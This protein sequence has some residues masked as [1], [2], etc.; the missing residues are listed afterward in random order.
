[1]AEAQ[2]TLPGG[3]P[4]ALNTTWADIQLAETTS[5]SGLERGLNNYKQESEEA[6]NAQ[7][8]NE[9]GVYRSI[10]NRMNAAGGLTT[11]ANTRGKASQYR[12]FAERRTQRSSAL[13]RRQGQYEQS[14]LEREQAGKKSRDEVLG[15]GEA[16]QREQ[17][18][19]KAANEP[20]APAPPAASAQPTA[21]APPS[22]GLGQ[23]PPG[24]E[25]VKLP[26]GSYQLQQAYRTK[27]TGGYGKSPGYR[28]F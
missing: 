18:A 19:I 13:Q 17:A 3:L 26:G 2:P 20:A 27:Y 22:P 12:T 24:Y 25:W 5:L 23:A 1:M 9:P 14:K 8:A 6:E 4:S 10:A 7:K 28:T 16:W 21:P 15:Q 11:G